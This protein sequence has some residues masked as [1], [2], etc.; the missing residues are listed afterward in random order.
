M[1]DTDRPASRAR[2]PDLAL[3]PVDGG[4]P[5][6]L[7]MARQGALLVLLDAA[8]TPEVT[9]WLGELAAAEPTFRGWD[10]R[11]LVVVG[12][13]AGDPA[14][15][16]RAALAALAL[17]FPVLSDARGTVAAVA[18]I[19]APGVV[20]A[21]QWGEVHAAVAGPMPVREVEEWLRFLAIRCAG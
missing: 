21:D 8:P 17:P 7:R 18:G 13:A 4:A 15:D 10:G 20:V 1:S 19:A 14:A 12:T 5:V 16:A 2:L 9:R 6:P 3:P 11:V